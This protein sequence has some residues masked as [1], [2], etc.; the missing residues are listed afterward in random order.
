MYNKGRKRGFM[1]NP[2]FF[3]SLEW[4]NKLGTTEVLALHVFGEPLLHDKFDQLALIAS[5]SAP[6]TMSTNC[7]L[8]DEAWADRLAKIPWAWI[9]LSDWKAGAAEKAARLLVPRGIRVQFPNGITHDWAGQAE[10]PK[11]KLFKGCP[12][13]DGGHAVIRWNG[14]VASCC[15]TDRVEDVVGHINQEPETIQMR[16]YSICAGCHH[17]Q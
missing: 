11:Q 2:T 13:L 16:P 17:A 12:F 10:G 5:K 8:L 1:D 6:V 9:S 15:I 3:R 14:D 4:V 7:V